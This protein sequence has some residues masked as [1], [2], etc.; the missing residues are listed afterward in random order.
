MPELKPYMIYDLIQ[1]EKFLEKFRFLKGKLI[2]E[3]SVEEFITYVN[4]KNNSFNVKIQASIY[5]TNLFLI[6][7]DIEYNEFERYRDYDEFNLL[8][9]EEINH[10]KE[11]GI[12]CY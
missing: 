7:D 8:M 11:D 6:K 10:I 4:Q 12:K 1:K 3:D 2:R 9:K 5:E